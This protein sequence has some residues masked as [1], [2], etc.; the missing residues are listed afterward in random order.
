MRGT[1][2]ADDQRHQSQD[3]A[4]DGLEPGL[5]RMRQLARY[6]YH[7]YRDDGYDY[8]PITDL[9]V[10]VA[11]FRNPLGLDTDFDSDDDTESSRKNDEYRDL[12]QIIN[13]GEGRDEVEMHEDVHTTMA[14]LC[15]E[16]CPSME[17]S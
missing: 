4:S 6:S 14:R 8:L 10:V 16:R 3:Q 7:V 12:A 11:A 9:F 13:D 1:T 5:V 2:E 17:Q 15:D